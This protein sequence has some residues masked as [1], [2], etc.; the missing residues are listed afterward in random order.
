MGELSRGNHGEGAL[1]SQMQLD[2]P[3]PVPID[4]LQGVGTGLNG[5]PTPI[6]F[7]EET[8][9][10]VVFPRPQDQGLF[11]VGGVENGHALSLEQVR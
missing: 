4:H 5:L 8:L 11:S 9:G 6:P 3:L 1:Q 10:L 7:V 2:A